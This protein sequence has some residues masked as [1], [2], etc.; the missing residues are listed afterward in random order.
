MAFSEA[1]AQRIRQRLAWR[2]VEPEGVE[3]DDQLTA[4][5]QRAVKFVG[6]LPAK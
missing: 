4:W 5:I 2:K 3:D 6:K 1:L